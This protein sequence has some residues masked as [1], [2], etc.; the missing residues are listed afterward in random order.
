M[1]DTTLAKRYAKAL[2]DIGLE[3]NTLDSYGADLSAF[4]QLIESSRD[5]KEVLI[6]PVFTKEDKKKIAG[7]V[8]AKMSADPMVINFINVCIISIK[9]I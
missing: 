8:L 9:I 1:I 6:S 2:V 3:N 5:L 7:D 4:T